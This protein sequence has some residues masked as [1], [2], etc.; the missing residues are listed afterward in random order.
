MRSWCLPE[1]T[2]SVAFDHPRPDALKTAGGPL[3]ATR[4]ALPVHAYR[5][6]LLEALTHRVSIVEGETGSGKTTQ[7]RAAPRPRPCVAEAAAV[8]SGGCT[9]V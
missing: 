5:D 3:A 7:A 9:R 2:D 8:C 6:R 4:E 1:V